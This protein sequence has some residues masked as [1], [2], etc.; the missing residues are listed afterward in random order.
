ML[1][2]ESGITDWNEDLK[3]QTEQIGACKGLDIKQRRGK[4]R[5][6]KK[7]LLVLVVQQTQIWMR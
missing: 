3:L 4:T 6:S 5:K 2:S 1:K 7:S